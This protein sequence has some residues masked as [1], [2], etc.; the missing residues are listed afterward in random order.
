VAQQNDLSLGYFLS[1]NEFHEFILKFRKCDIKNLL[2][3]FIMIGIGEKPG[4]IVV[5]FFF[6]VNF[7]QIINDTGK[8]RI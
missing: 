7:Y 4:H 3:N 8:F 6:P 5:E 1:S 2:E